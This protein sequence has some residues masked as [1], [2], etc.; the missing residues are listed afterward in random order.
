MQTHAVVSRQVAK[1]MPVTVNKE[2]NTFKHIKI[3]NTLGLSYY[4][5]AN[6]PPSASNFCF[7]DNTPVTPTGDQPATAV[8]SWTLNIF[9]KRSE[10]AE[11]M[12][13]PWNHVA[14]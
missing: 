1:F 3:C 13:N 8:R 14:L 10:I 12:W 5:R 9:T 6:F 2:D 7:E 4:N 11:K